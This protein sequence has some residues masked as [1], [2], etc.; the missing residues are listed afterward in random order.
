M[1]NFLE[2]SIVACVMFFSQLAHAFGVDGLDL[3]VRAGSFCSEGNT[4]R[5]SSL[6]LD[7]S[8][9]RESFLPRAETFAL[10]EATTWLRLDSQGRSGDRFIGIGYRMQV[11]KLS[12]LDLRYRGSDRFSIL[13]RRQF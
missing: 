3:T 1:R 9:S 13:Y 12:L 5:P 4:H 6:H 10:A 7:R 2:Y 8:C 11:E